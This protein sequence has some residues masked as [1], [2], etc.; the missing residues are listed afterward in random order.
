MN[1]TI[2]SFQVALDRA[3][4]I[5]RDYPA[6]AASLLPKQG[7]EPPFAAPTDIPGLAGKYQRQL[8]WEGNV[9]Q[10]CVH[11]HQIG[12][13]YRAWYRG[14]G[15]SIP[16][17]WIYPMP[18]PTTVGLKLDPRNPRKVK[19]TNPRSSAEKMGLQEG[20]EIVSIDGA[21]IVSGADVSWA[22]HRADDPGK[23]SIQWLRNTE[24]VHGVL[25]LSEG[26]RS[27]SDISRRVGTW[28]MRAMALGGMVLKDLNEAQRKAHK[29]EKDG[30]GLQVEHVGEYGEHAAAK[31]AGFQVGDIL[32]AIEGIDEPMS[33]SQLIGRLLSK[34]LTPIRLSTTVL[35]GQDRLI[36]DLP[37]Q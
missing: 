14:K 34:H 6:N 15:E 36:L 1:T 19:G 5:H 4:E 37:V 17:D 9:V 27:N 33:E 13:A 22:L 29:I 30:F 35:R 21:P 23:L 11:C 16:A 3:L 10:S 25:E 24:L 20:D 26:W 8:N 28:Q 2:D 32:V 18:D 12:D 7:R 31:R